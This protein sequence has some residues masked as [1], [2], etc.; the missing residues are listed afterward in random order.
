MVKDLERSFIVIKNKLDIR[1]IIGVIIAHFLM[2]ITF[3]DKAI[4]WYMFTATML[5]LISYSILNERAEEKTP[6]IKNSFY[7][8]LSG[9]ILFLLFWAGNFIIDSFH[10]S[11]SNDISKLY[12]NFSPTAIWQYFILLLIIVPGEEIFWRGFVQRRL[13]RK[14]GTT[15]SIIIST[16][17]YASVQI[18]SGYIIH[19]FAA[20]IAGLFW[21][22]L[23][24]RKRS[25][26]LVIV[27]HFVFDLCLFILFPFR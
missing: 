5:I 7:G 6:L 8:I 18:Y 11:F 2:Y 22:I 25:L 9:I 4:F 3:H 17:L 21:G 14:L 13:S 26:P 15:T 10:L 27:S 24:A 16:I 19:I 1:V 12:R 23:Y 20:I